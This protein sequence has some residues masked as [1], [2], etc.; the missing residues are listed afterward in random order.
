MIFHYNPADEYD[1]Y[2]MRREAQDEWNYKHAHCYWCCNSRDEDG[3]GEP[4][5]DDEGMY[6]TRNEI[7]VFGEDRPCDHKCEWYNYY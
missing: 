2:E 7:F 1:R 5:E 4:L 3:E 6:C